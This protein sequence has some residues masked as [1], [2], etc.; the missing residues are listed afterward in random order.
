M[1]RV[2]H[3]ASNCLKRATE[4]QGGVFH[5]GRPAVVVVVGLLAKVKAA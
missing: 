5:M 4:P 3:Y 2:L 1:V